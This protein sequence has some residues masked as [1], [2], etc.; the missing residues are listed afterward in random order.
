ML[1][2]HAAG[3]RP[4]HSFVTYEWS[5][6]LVQHED[7]AKYFDGTATWQPLDRHASV[8]ATG[9]I[10]D[11]ACGPGRHA[12]A[13]RRAGHDV[14]GIDASPGAVRVATA[15]GID[16]RTATVDQLP[17]GLGRFDTILLIGGGLFLL[18]APGR[19]RTVLT[20]L[21]AAASPGA[22][23]WG[24]ATPPR[25]FDASVHSTT[26]PLGVRTR[27]ARTTGPWQP[28]HLPTPGEISTAAEQTPWT[29]RRITH[30]GTSYLAELVFTGHTG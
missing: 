5:D 10:L 25:T 29:V 22:V 3:A 1:C 18:G 19:A 13:L 16:A 15:H 7:A 9:R 30:H 17:A 24:R 23:L 14:T 21:A 2:C 6:G 27:H 28:Y 26:A 8:Q 4:G 12:T 11:V 20:S